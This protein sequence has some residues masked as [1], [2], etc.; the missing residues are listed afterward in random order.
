MAEHGKQVERLLVVCQAMSFA[1][2]HGWPRWGPDEV[3]AVVVKLAAT[4]G[5][6]IQ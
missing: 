5:F 3:G 1:S 2:G 4:R 6:V